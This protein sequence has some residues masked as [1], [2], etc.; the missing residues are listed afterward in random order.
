MRSGRS[1]RS[2]SRGARLVA[3]RA[4]VGRGGAST[5]RARAER[6]RGREALLAG[7]AAAGS[8]EE[9]AHPDPGVRGGDLRSSSVTLP[10]ASSCWPSCS[11]SAG[12]GFWR[13]RDA[14]A[15]IAAADA[16]RLAIETQ[17]IRD[18]ATARRRR[19]ARDARAGRR[20][21]RPVGGRARARRRRDPAIATDLLVNEASLTG[22]ELPGREG[23]GR[24]PRRR[25]AGGADE[26][27]CSRE[28]T[29]SAGTGARAWSSRRARAPHY[30][31]IAGACGC[32][33]PRPSSSAACGSS[34]TCWPAR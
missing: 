4:D 17:V 32:G 3:R 34:A 26:H 22:R 20:I 15:A 30:G 27:A 23:R 9:P 33:R 24:R 10:T 1:R 16:A 25:A 8:G 2:W 14:R 29:S 13:E 11:V 7:A 19:A 5:G 21:V 12:I 18:G 28:R 6:G 31:A